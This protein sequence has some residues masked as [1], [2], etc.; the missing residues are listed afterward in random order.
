MSD[1]A[2][3]NE[4]LQKELSRQKRLATRALASYQQ[5]ALQMELIRQQNED[6]DRLAA[7]LA[8][9]KRVAEDRARE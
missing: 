6:L 7:D 8:R 4:R 2:E 1:L 9:A 5:R 3:E